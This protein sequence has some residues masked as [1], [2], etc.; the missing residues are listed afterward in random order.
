MA[1]I[2]EE[3]LVW[4]FGSGD[5]SVH[6][7]PNYEHNKGTRLKCITNDQF[8]TYGKQVLGVNLVWQDKPTDHKVH[9]VTA[10]KKQREL[11]TGEP[12]AFGIGGGEA[13]LYYKSRKNGIN[14]DWSEN[15]HQEWRIFGPSGKKGERIMSGKNYAIV[16]VKVKPEPDFL[17]YFNR[18]MPGVCDIGWTTSPAWLNKFI[19][20]GKLLNEIR[21]EIV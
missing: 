13:F 18:E 2:P 8:L 15:P 20:A 14:L 10:D 11:L 1:G 3:V 19:K 9:L 12:F 17:I 4:Q 16:N 6:T 5:G 7:Q 21:K